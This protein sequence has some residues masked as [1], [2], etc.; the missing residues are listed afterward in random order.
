MIVMR[1]PWPDLMFKTQER[2]V[3]YA[4]R[5]SYE[6][7]CTTTIYD[8]EVKVAAFSAGKPDA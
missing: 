5:Y 7:D 8:G 4:R 2:A 6:W 1:S 3:E